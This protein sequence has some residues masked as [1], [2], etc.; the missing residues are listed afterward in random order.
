MQRLDDSP[1]DRL[2]EDLLLEDEVDPRDELEELLDDFLDKH[3]DF[4]AVLG[5]SDLLFDFIVVRSTTKWM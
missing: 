3:S 5:T 4:D 1:A 2:L